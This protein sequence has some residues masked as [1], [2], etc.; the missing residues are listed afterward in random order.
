MDINIFKRAF[1]EVQSLLKD[2][3]F[4]DFDPALCVTLIQEF[5]LLQQE[6]VLCFGSTSDPPSDATTPPL[7]L[8][9]QKPYYEVDYVGPSRD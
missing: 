3:H 9:F 6:L 5:M 4:Q 7:V 8:V 1:L 2:P